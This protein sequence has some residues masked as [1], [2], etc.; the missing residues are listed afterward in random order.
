[1]DR[2]GSN[3]LIKSLKMFKESSV[4]VIGM[5]DDRKRHEMEGRWGA[6]AHCYTAINTTITFEKPLLRH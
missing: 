1:M 3:H 5:H 2:I 6:L 4:L